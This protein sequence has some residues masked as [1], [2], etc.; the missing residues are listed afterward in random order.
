MFFKK[1]KYDFKRMVCDPK[2]MVSK[3]ATNHTCISNNLFKIIE[4][5]SDLWG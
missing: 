5:M 4:I 2:G 1:K 3:Y